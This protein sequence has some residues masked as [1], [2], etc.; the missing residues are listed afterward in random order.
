MKEERMQILRMVEA[1]KITAADAAKLFEALKS[2]SV[3]SNK[4]WK[5]EGPSFDERVKEFSKN[6]ES[7]AKD[8]GSKA[9]TLYKDGVQPKVKK[10]TRV[11]VEKTAH[12]VE[13]LS[14]S[15]NDTVKG[16]ENA[17]VEDDEECCCCCDGEEHDDDCCCEDCEE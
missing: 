10:A 1:G 2:D 13:E 14:R 11:V 5:Q 8:L 4:E 3:G 6:A 16:F 15:L 9:S 17:E 12:V 7:F